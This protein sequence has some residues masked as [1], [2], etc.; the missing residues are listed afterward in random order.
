MM[1]ATEIT[2]HLLW[3]RHDWYRL[4]TVLTFIPAVWERY[5]YRPCVVGGDAESWGVKLLP[6]A[7]SSS[8]R[9]R[10]R[11]WVLLFLSAETACRR[12]SIVVSALW[13]IWVGGKGQGRMKRGLALL[14]VLWGGSVCINDSNVSSP[15]ARRTDVWPAKLRR[16]G[17][18]L[19]LA[20]HSGAWL[21]LISY[22][23]RLLISV[24][25]HKPTY[26]DSPVPTLSGYHMSSL[27]WFSFR[28]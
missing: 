24:L 3:A 19:S 11:S 20:S 9:C 28:A 12:V 4:D 22:E 16:T 26:Q 13:S 25:I 15:E 7:W 14:E 10:I 18:H 8:Y 5:Y 6:K 17:Q 23:S 1:I 27:L 2:E 21:V